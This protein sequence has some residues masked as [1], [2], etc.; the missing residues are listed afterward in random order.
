MWCFA[1]GAAAIAMFAA[2]LTRIRL[3]D[4][5]GTYKGI[6]N[7]GMGPVYLVAISLALGILAW[8]VHRSGSSME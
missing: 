1:V 3:Y 5:E 6:A 7:I 2:F 4:S 8:L